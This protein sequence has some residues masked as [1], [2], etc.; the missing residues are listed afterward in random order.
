MSIAKGTTNCMMRK[1]AQDDIDFCF[2][3]SLVLGTVWYIRS[4]LPSTLL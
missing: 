3:Q 2:G 1:I 4:V